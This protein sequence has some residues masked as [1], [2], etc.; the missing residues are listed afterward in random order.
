VAIGLSYV[1]RYVMRCWRPHR[2]TGALIGLLVLVQQGY[3]ALVAYSLKSLVDTV[4]P[5]EDIARFAT[6]VVM[7]A[8]AWAAAAAAGIGTEILAA[9]TAGAILTALRARLFRHIQSL[10]LAFFSRHHSADLVTRFTSDLAEIERGVTSRLVDFVIAIIG[11]LIYLPLLFALD[12]RLTALVVVGLPFAIVGGNKVA[13][14]AQVARYELR[15]AEGVMAAAVAENVR[16]QAVVKLFGLADRASSAFDDKLERVR[17]EYVKST[18]LS[19]LVGTTSTF[20]VLLFQAIV[21]GVGAWLALVGE[22]KPGSLVAFVTLHA[23]VS[24]Q[25]Y[26]LAKKVIPSLIGA[27]AGIQ[28]LDELLGEKP[29]VADKEGSF[30]LPHAT[31]DIQFHKV[32]FGYPGES[33]SLIDLDLVIP[34]G[35][36]VAIVGGSGSGKSTVLRL[37]MRLYDPELGIVTIGNFDLR[38]VSLA[39]LH[40]EIGV[41][42][43]EALLVDDTIAENIRVGK[44]D[45]TREEIEAAAKAAEVHATIVSNPAGY[46]TRIGEAGGRLSG[47]ERQRIAIARALVRDP[48]LLV[49]DEATSALDPDSED[50]IGKT[51]EKLSGRT[52]VSVTHRLTSARGMDRIIV[53]ANGGVAE[54]GTHDELVAKGGIYATM[55]RKQS[56][57]HVS[58][59]GARVDEAWLRDIPLLVRAPAELLAKIATSVVLE[60][61]PAETTV[62]EK[63][64]VGDKLYIVARGR[65]AVLVDDDVV[66][67]LGDGEFFGEL[68]L[69]HNIRRSATVRTVTPCWFL[70]LTREKLDALL[71]D[72][73]EVRAEIHRVAQARTAEQR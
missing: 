47:G 38:E 63:G 70:T 13:G 39:S 11:L 17:S 71:A 62:F 16:T 32:T 59:S 61:V 15:T 67:T 25:T 73:P 48:S 72:A 50:A 64:Q 28:R 14:R 8:V 36:R 66:A 1:V 7:L 6:I 43:Q 55:W 29:E 18:A 5:A 65:A 10:S 22:M 69:L 49:L 37:L 51:L 4:I 52:I 26:D 45:A 42:F 57:V 19:A 68:A 60:R 41:V 9:R 54:E 23:A 56:G 46:E 40:K 24:K 44:A 53:L 31:A 3:G 12:W 20:A 58:E 27:S 2:K 35:S 21:M 30:V 34:A 33:P